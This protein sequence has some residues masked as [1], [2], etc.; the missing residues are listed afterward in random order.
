MF[1]LRW[2]RRHH[3]LHH[4]QRVLASLTDTDFVSVRRRSNDAKRQ[5]YEFYTTDFK[6]Y[7]KSYNKSYNKYQDHRKHTSV[8]HCTVY[9][10]VC[11]RVRVCACVCVRVSERGR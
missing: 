3:S 9:P 5:R 6:P 4:S 11:V 2:E 8:Q 10:R 7:N 1:V